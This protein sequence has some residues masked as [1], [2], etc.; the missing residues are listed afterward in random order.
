MARRLTKEL[1]DLNQN[2][3]DFATASPVGED[4]LHWNAMLMGPPSTPYDGGVFNVD[5]VFP[6]E[7][8]F[9][10]P[11]VK[12][13]TKIYHPNIKKDSGEI[14]ADLLTENWGP[15]LNTRYVLTTLKT[16]LEEPNAD[17]PLEADI[18]SQFK[19]DKAA[20]ETTAKDFTQRF[21]T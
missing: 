15:T 21:A 7:Y 1:E 3:P 10:P 14:C 8:P 6:S 2:P 17:N 12:F 11:K 4:L 18:A 20:F 19:D 9:K 5:L 16:L 13:L